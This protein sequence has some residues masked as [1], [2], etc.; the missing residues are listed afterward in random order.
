MG[1]RPWGVWR[2]LMGMSEQARFNLCLDFVD[3]F[4]KCRSMALVYP[5]RND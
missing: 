3:A 1:I 5:G 4:H 2:V